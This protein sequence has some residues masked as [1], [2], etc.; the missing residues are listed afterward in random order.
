MSRTL[1]LLGSMVAGSM[2]LH[3]GTLNLSTGLDASGNLITSDLGCDAHWTV[4]GS[5]ACSGG[6]A[7]VVMPG[8]AD[9]YGGWPANGPNSAAITRNASVQD[10]GNPLPTFSVNFYLADTTGA[11]LSGSWGIDDG[12]YIALNGNTLATGGCCISMSGVSSST[13]FVTGLNTLSIVMTST[14]DFLEGVR[15]EGSV[16]GDLTPEPG[17]IL[18]FATGLGG[19]IWRRR[20]A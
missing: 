8:D 9:W 17:T 5:G 13:G 10:N 18:L 16:S 15:F 2:I 14:D 12:G 4:T 11:S 1:L 3:G 20:L 19:L 7:Q 6:A